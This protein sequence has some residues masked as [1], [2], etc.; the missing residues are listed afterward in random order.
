MPNMS[1]ESQLM[2]PWS[3]QALRVPTTLERPLARLHLRET[4]R[5]LGFSLLNTRIALATTLLE[6]III[7]YSSF[8]RLFLLRLPIL[9]EFDWPRRLSWTGE[10]LASVPTNAIVVS[11]T[12][13]A[14][15]TQ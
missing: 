10:I 15:V 12:L 2:P 7:L 11:D 3:S 8:A 6:D 1:S 14:S 5:C 4:P 9:A 13:A